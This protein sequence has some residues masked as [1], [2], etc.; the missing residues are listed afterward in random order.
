MVELRVIEAGDQ[1]G[2]AGAARCEADA[3]LAGEFRMGDGHERGHFFVPR[4]DEVDSSVALKRADDA[5]DAIAR[6]AEDPLDAPGLQ[7]M[8]EEICCFHDRNNAA[9]PPMLR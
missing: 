2:G 1:V 3:D 7:P 4:L 9:A 6:V 5:V 8:H